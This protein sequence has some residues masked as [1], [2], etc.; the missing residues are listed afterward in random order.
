MFAVLRFAVA[1]EAYDIVVYGGTSGGVSAAVQA[2]RMGKSVV[3]IEPGQHLGGLTASG[4]GFVDVGNVS[5]IG[6]L[7]REYFHRVWKFYQADAAWKMEGRRSLPGQHKPLPPGEQTLWLVEP[8][9]GERL[10]DEMITEAKVTVVRGERLNRQT[11]VRKDGEK[12]V[13]LEMESGRIITGKVFI[14]TTYE[15]DLMA[16]AGVSYFIGREPN[17]RY[18]ETLNGLH[19]V[20]PSGEMPRQVDPYVEPGNPASGLL[21]RV[22]RLAAE[23]PGAEDQRVQAYCY[24]MCLTDVVT[25]RVPVPKP[26]G[27]D[28]GQYEIVFRALEAGLAK[29]RFFKLSRMPNRKTDSNNH[30]PVSTDL[31][32]SSSDYAGA[33]Y[34]TRERLAREHELWQRGLIWT[35][36]HHPRVPPAV[37]DYYAPWGLAKDEFTDNGNWPWQLYV[38][39]AR[40]MVGDY[41]ITENTA[42]GRD[43]GTNP[44]GLG[45]YHMDS[46]HTQYIVAADGMLATE[47][48]F[49]EKVPQPFPIN[50][51][52]IVPKRGECSNLLVPV[53]LSASHVAYGSVRME[54]V[55]MVLGQSAA[56]AAA[57]ALDQNVPVQ[58]VPA[59]ILQPRLKA[60][61]QITKWP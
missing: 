43:A 33:D 45:S 16:A 61:G 55:F 7:A 30:G 11:G 1:T 3:L 9:V 34:A 26:A 29:E 56:T 32:G 13:S 35:L 20:P 51:Q 6:G 24:R 10:F 8:S 49:F 52:S 17:S 21:P 44:I 38:R 41:V 59:G 4:L 37:R 47:G 12:I 19:I 28:E 48:G 31:I 36:Q 57:I 46:H 5:T 14:D 39:E 53:C 54:P 18:H 58:S 25:N 60:D 27:Y 15:G 42:R 50:Y 40:R 2:A 23:K 22:N